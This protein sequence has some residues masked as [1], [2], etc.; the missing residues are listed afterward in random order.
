[1]ATAT[2]KE[3]RKPRKE[4]LF[5]S[6]TGEYMTNIIRDSWVS[7]TPKHALRICYE[8]LGM[9]TE[10][11]LEVITGKKKLTGDTRYDDGLGWEDDNTTEVCGIKLDIQTMV[12]RLEKKYIDASEGINVLNNGGDRIVD[13]MRFVDS[14]VDSDEMNENEG[15]LNYYKK[16][17]ADAIEQLEAVYPLVG[18]S[19]KDLP[20][21]KVR[22]SAKIIREAKKQ[23][24]KDDF[25]YNNGKNNLDEKFDNVMRFSQ[26]AILNNLDKDDEEEE[27]QEKKDI[28]SRFYTRIGGGASFYISHCD[29]RKCKD[30][31]L[32]A[33]WLLPDGTFFGGD[34]IWIHRGILDELS[35]FDFFKDKNYSADE[36]DVQDRGNWIKYSG[37]EWMIWEF[38]HKL[39][40]EQ[41]EF[42]IEY[43]T[44]VNQS[45]V[46]TINSFYKIHI[47]VFAKLLD[48]VTQFDSSAMKEESEPIIAAEI[49]AEKN[50]KDNPLANFPT[51]DEVSSIDPLST[52]FFQPDVD[53][54]KWLI[55]YADGRTI[56]DCGAGSGYLTAMI[57]HLGYKNCIA[58]EPHYT[59]ERNW[60]WRKRGFQFHV[61]FKN[62]EE[63]SI[64]RDIP[65]GKALL[66]FARPCHSGFVYRT[67]KNNM[68]VGTEALYISHKNNTQLDLGDIYYTE[69]KHEGTSKNNE[70]VLSIKK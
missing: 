27:E 44:I 10:Q 1:M 31:G 28:N 5:F 37:G 8:S 13:K 49:E 57:H 17:V 32:H 16:R 38:K 62:S 20:V 3:T 2:K 40:K 60:F 15:T 19:M 9:T 70:F 25:E 26:E 64:I 54:V 39:T 23:Q 69:L 35:E 59:E 33:G 52:P 42:I 58:I 34:G 4:G 14:E 22:S 53:F 18:K 36:D 66:L 29:V 68:P 41:I 61:F 47:S 7:D 21:N 43:T 30:E 24:I 11:A 6:T 55:K 12:D 63:E 51:I 65:K 50:R 67:I 45:T 46:L 48:G 56:I